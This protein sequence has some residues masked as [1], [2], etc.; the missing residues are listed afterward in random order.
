MTNEEKA[1]IYNF[2]N[3]KEQNG[4]QSYDLFANTCPKEMLF[5]DITDLLEMIKTFTETGKPN[6]KYKWEILPM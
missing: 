6:L 2:I 4:E 5:Y 3:D 1:E